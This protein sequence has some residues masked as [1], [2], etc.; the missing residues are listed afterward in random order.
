MEP[1][2]TQYFES[3]PGFNKMEPLSTQ[4]YCKPTKDVEP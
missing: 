2:S 4:Y 3:E 1:L